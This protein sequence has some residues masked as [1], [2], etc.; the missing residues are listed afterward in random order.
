MRPCLKEG[1]KEG[2]REERQGEGGE[3]EGKEER[4]GEG[5]GEGEGEREIEMQTNFDIVRLEIHVVGRGTFQRD[6]N[7]SWCT[8]SKLFPGE[9]KSLHF[10]GEQGQ[11]V[12]YLT[13]H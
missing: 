3:K 7:K 10:L 1:E 12:I 4:Q 11:V 9:E 8:C 13:T 5:E 6:L 2:R